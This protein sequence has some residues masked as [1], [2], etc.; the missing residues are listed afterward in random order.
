MDFD[1]LDDAEVVAGVGLSVEL[2]PEL[3]TILEVTAAPDAFKEYLAEQH[4]LTC[5]GVSEHVQSPGD[6]EEFRKECEK[7]ALRL[8]PP[9]ETTKE[10]VAIRNVVRRCRHFLREAAGE[11]E[12]PAAP[13]PKAPDPEAPAETAALAPAAAKEAPAKEASA[14]AKAEESPGE[15]PVPK[16]EEAL[17]V[18]KREEPEPPA[19]PWVCDA[20]DGG[21]PSGSYAE[22]IDAY[23]HG[24]MTGQVT[25]KAPGRPAREPGWK[26]DGDFEAIR[27]K[28]EGS[29]AEL[30]SQGVKPLSPF[31]KLTMQDL[32]KVACKVINGEMYG[33]PVPV[34]LDDFKKRGER[35]L[36]QAFHAAGTLK[37]DNSVKKILEF[38]RLP[39]TG[40]LAA[41]GSGPKAFLTVEYAKEDP[42]LHRHLFCKMPWD[43]GTNAVK[44]GT[45]GD[46]L[47]PEEQKEFYRLKEQGVDPFYRWKCSATIDYEAQ[48]ATIYRFLGPIFPF[49]IPKY[50]FADICRENTNY[51]LITEKIAYPKRGEAREPKPYDILPVAEKYFDFQLQP[52]MRHEMYY[53]IMRAQAR[54]AAWDKL[55]FFDIAPPEMRGQGMAPP[56]LG[57]FEW[58]RKVPP[59]RRAALARGGES[60][61][62]L[63]TEFLTDKAKS[64]YDKRFT[65]P[66]FLEALC[67]CAMESNAYKDDIF[68]YTCLFPDMV[69]LQHTNLQSDNAYYWYND[70]DEMDCGLIDWGGASPA[71]FSSRLS[72]SITS[73]EGSVLDEHEDGL[74][75]CFINE[76]YKECGIKLDFGELQRQ[77]MLCY[78]QY[79]TTMGTN[80][81]MEIFRETPRPM[82]KDIKDKW[83]DKA[84][85]RWNV[86]CYV[87]MIDHALEYLYLRW[88]RGGEKR[89]HCHDVLVEWKAY[90]ESKGMT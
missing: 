65:E 78:C 74:L 77:W 76:Y 49:R 53:A 81:E 21:A 69:A 62:K 41:G 90:W 72:G 38:K 7:L 9:A 30:A 82:W 75:R 29:R 11:A 33:L 10:Q 51:I 27:V 57:F 42:E 15:T 84:A 32:E 26:V 86:R 18:E 80:I 12:A 83:D 71:P 24:M 19:G 54:M 28:A 40:T 45:A 66:K 34:N 55:G 2:Q 4:I 8:K 50:Y 25:G 61:A 79:I 31:R 6:G 63:W 89:L 35:Y 23:I 59:K 1:D 3:L 20:W 17:P 13:A 87:F 70:K 43:M 58:P 22:Y 88:K 14:A 5:Q 39:M 36:T 73:A 85:G 46:T 64:L 52:R 60:N 16:A 68:L 47:T 44:V 67:S 37:K 56:P 48:E